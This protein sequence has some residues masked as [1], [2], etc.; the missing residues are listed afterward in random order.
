MKQLY[1]RPRY[2]FN[3]DFK[4][5]AEGVKIR[6]KCRWYKESEKSTKYVLNLKKGNQKNQFY[7]D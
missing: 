2:F 6:S 7:G 5:I 4:I 1:W 3:V